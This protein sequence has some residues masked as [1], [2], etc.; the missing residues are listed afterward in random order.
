LDDNKITG[1]TGSSG[2]LPVWINIMKQLRQKPVNL[3]QPDDVEWHWLDR[4]TGELSA[5]GCDGA[6]HIP[7][8][9]NSIPKRA[10]ACS[11]SQYEVQP[12]TSDTE[13]TQE[14][15]PQ[16][17]NL[18]NLIRESENNSDQDTSNQTRIVSSGSFTN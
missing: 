7:L 17:D 9:R 1:L 8:L 6:I 2:A 11:Q 16:S 10:T 3:R 15:A 12:Y 14:P 4:N 5:S 18:E 13:A